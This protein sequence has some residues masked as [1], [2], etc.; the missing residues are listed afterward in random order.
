MPRVRVLAWLVLLCGLCL[1]GCAA[2]PAVVLPPAL[3]GCQP[4]PP[5]PVGDDADFAEWVAAVVFAGR[6]CRDGL[7]RVVRLIEH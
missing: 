2:P 7:A 6:D 3:R 4:E 5:L 1:T